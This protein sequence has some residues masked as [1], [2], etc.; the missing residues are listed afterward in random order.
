MQWLVSEHRATAHRA[1]RLTGLSRSTW[2]YQLGSTE[3]EG[4]RQTI[5]DVA[6]AHPR[7]GYRFVHWSVLRQGFSAGPRRVRRLYRLEGLSVRKR[8]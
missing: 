5:R 3:P 7:R 4:L 6:Y 1:C 2:G 8:R